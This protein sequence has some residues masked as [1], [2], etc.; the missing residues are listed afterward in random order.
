MRYDKEAGDLM[1]HLIVQVN[2]TTRYREMLKYWRMWLAGCRMSF[3]NVV[4]I[5]RY[6][7]WGLQNPGA[8]RHRFLCRLPQLINVINDKYHHKRHSMIIIIIM[9]IKIEGRYTWLVSGRHLVQILAGIPA[10][11][12]MPHGFPLHTCLDRN[13]WHKCILLVPTDERRRVG[14][15]SIFEWNTH[16]GPEH[17]LPQTR[18][19]HYQ[20]QQE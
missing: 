2:S 9:V 14:T 15:Q 19:F 13:L 17:I 11:L 16:Y 10:V 4:H 18:R 8:S 5:I 12:L 1:K 20:L 3:S 7:A 6:E